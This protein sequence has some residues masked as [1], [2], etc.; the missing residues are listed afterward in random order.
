M[1]RRDGMDIPDITEQVSGF[2]DPVRGHAANGWQAVREYFATAWVFIRGLPMPILLLMYMVMITAGIGILLSHGLAIYRNRNRWVADPKSDLMYS[3]FIKS[4]AHQANLSYREAHKQIRDSHWIYSISGLTYRLGNIK[5]EAIGVNILLAVVYIPL[6]IL[7]VLEIFFRVTIGTFY[8]I[9]FKLIHKVLLFA[10]GFISRFIIIIA[11]IVDKNMRRKQYCTSCY[12]EIELP[13]FECPECNKQ[14]TRLVPSR[15]GA[16]FARC[17]CNK[18][19]LPT[20]HLT[21]RSRLLSHCPSRCNARLAAPNA[22]PV[23][24][25]LIGGESV[26]KTLFLSALHYICWNI[27]Q[28]QSK[29]YMS[30]Y[31]A[32]DRKKLGE[33][34][35]VNEAGPGTV[36]GQGPMAYN[37]RY[38]YKN[39]KSAIRDNLV[40]FDVDGNVVMNNSYASTVHFSFC[41]GFIIFVD[42]TQAS[43]AGSDSLSTSTPGRNNFYEV[44]NQFKIELLNQHEGRIGKKIDVPIAVVIAKMDIAPGAGKLAHYTAT[45]SAAGN[46]ACKDYLASLGFGDALQSIDLSFNNVAYFPVSSHSGSGVSHSQVLAPVKW[47]LSKSGGR[48][49]KVL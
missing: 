13:V 2:L 3:Y 18:C 16:L 7:S 28:K 31:P 43:V 22:S 27:S 44:L 45:G 35:M 21:G 15:S 1:I 20:M 29:V 8:F 24:I 26:G 10:A 5:H 19:F 25:H 9:V 46:K 37:L 32:K 38:R 6:A 14:H 39:K 48:L 41:N 36:D 17:A 11:D 34:Y 12:A 30:G 23:Y 49:L 33:Y 40:V 4:G 47:I 42:P